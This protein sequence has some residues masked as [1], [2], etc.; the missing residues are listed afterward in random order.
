MAD[1]PAKASAV[2]QTEPSDP[3]TTVCVA[4]HVIG[5]LAGNPVIPNRKPTPVI[6]IA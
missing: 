3:V 5:V 1:A 6:S 4:S 2:S